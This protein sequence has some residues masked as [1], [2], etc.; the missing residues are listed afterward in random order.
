LAGQEGA[1]PRGSPTHRAEAA[2]HRQRQK[3]GATNG[4]QAARQT[5]E[6][7]QL[8]VPRPI[9]VAR[10]NRGEDPAE[11]RAPSVFHMVGVEV[12]L[13]EKSSENFCGPRN[14]G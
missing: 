3:S 10:E 11:N 5:G 8:I 12:V 6:A 9:E 7:S 13:I 14:Q 1:A 4:D 2:A